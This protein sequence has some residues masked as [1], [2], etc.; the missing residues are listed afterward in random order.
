MWIQHRRIK[1]ARRQRAAEAS[2]LQL[3]APPLDPQRNSPSSKDITLGSNNNNSGS[4]PASATVHAAQQGQLSRLAAWWGQVLQRSEGGIA[5]TWG[6]VFK[7]FIVLLSLSLVGVSGWGIAKSIQ[8]SD[9][10]ISNFWGIVD[11]GEEKV[12]GLGTATS[13][14]YRAFGCGWGWGLHSV[15]ARVCYHGHGCLGCPT[16]CTAQLPC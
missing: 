9:H 2:K 6:R 11:V 4:P 14:R 12:R 7:V 13:S 8:A 3:M 1:R 5:V 15:R 10:T 16:A